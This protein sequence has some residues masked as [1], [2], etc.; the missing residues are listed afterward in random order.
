MLAQLGKVSSVPVQ[1]Y[2]SLRP[3][4]V[5]TVGFSIL[6]IVYG[7]DDARDILDRPRLPSRAYLRLFMSL[8]SSFFHW[9]L[10]GSIL[11]II[12]IGE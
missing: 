3:D 10:N 11:H 2:Q 5:F 9:K 7:R 8:P 4:R 12:S 1:E 6:D